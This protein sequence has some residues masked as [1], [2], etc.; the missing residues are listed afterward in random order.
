MFVM[1]QNTA[2]MIQIQMDTH[3]AVTLRIVPTSDNTK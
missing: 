1:V 3:L 2:Q